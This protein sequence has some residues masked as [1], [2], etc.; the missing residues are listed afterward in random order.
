MVK[1][2][3]H[4]YFQIKYKHTPAWVRNV[5]IQLSVSDLMHLFHG[6]P[7]VGS[8]SL[9]DWTGVIIDRLY[10]SRHRQYERDREISHAIQIS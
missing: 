8:V 6:R 10:H 9:R 4:G 7:T 1:C 5:S 3:I 2:P